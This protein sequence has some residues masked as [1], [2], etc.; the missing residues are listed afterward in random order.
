[1]TAY[2]VRAGTD[3]IE[4]EVADGGDGLRVRAGERSHRVEVDELVPGWCVLVVDG[5]PHD[6]GV[7]P[8]GGETGGARGWNLVLDGYTYVVSVSRGS[9]RPA[10]ARAGAADAGTHDVRAPMPGLLVAVQVGEGDS[11]AAGQPLVVMEAMKM[12]ME[13]R[14]PGGGVVRRVHATPGVEVSAGQVLVTIA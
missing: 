9:R 10:G 12:Q 11:V 5:R 8:G 2:V 14:A 13:I 6:L 1:V 3:E 4:I 7:L